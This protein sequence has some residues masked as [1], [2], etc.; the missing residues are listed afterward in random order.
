[1]PRPSPVR[2]LV[3]EL[4]AGDARHAWSLDE[5]LEHVRSRGGSAD[6]STVFRVVTALERG[7]EIRRISMDDGKSRYEPGGD[8]HEHIA[9]GRCGRI[10]EVPGCLVEDAAAQIRS[11]TGY[12]VAG[13][14][15]VFSGTCPDCRAGAAVAEGA[16]QA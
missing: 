10:A 13:H 1:M 8:H 12:E 9:C 7:G 4:L 3:R 2:D 11:A 5:L 6:Y 14:R 16:S 15:L